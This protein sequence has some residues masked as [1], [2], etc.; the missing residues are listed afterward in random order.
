MTYQASMLK[1]YDSLFLTPE[2]EHPFSFILEIETSFLFNINV[3]ITL[4]MI[5]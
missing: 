1:R 2:R 5:A 3:V 4:N